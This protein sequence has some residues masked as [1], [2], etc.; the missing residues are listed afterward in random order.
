M[1]EEP[2]PMILGK[3][4]G[5]P[6][7]GQEGSCPRLS[8]QKLPTPALGADGFGFVHPAFDELLTS[9]GEIDGC[10]KSLCMDPEN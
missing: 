2:M 1:F 7:G 9:Y 5:R 8:L 10:R 6:K 4:L 3:I